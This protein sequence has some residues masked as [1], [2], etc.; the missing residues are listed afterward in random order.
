MNEQEL[1]LE[2]KKAMENPIYLNGHDNVLRIADGKVVAKVYLKEYEGFAQR[3]FRIANELYLLHPVP[4]MH[5][6]LD[7]EEHGVDFK[8]YSPFA[9]KFYSARFSLFMDFFDGKYIFEVSNKLLRE[10]ICERVNKA[11]ESIKS[12][13]YFL[14][15]T[16]D[17]NMLYN[18]RTD[19]FCLLD[20]DGWNLPSRKS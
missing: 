10:N 20:F 2:F 7:L 16:H 9:K 12:L 18:E 3:Y 4:K 6:L 13:G 15:D 17:K 5:S 11:Y 14:L 8:I 1:I 19:R